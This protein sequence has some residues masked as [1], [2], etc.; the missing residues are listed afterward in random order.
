MRNALK[1]FQ[2]RTFA[3]NEIIS[4]CA[5]RDI[6]AIVKG[7]DKCLRPRF[8]S[9]TSNYGKIIINILLKIRTCVLSLISHRHEDLCKL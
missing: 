1:Q 4:M 8:F 2:I 5:E 3:L 9:S 6:G 7:R